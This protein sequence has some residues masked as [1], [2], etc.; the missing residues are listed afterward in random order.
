[1]QK[2]GK[3]RRGL[4]VAIAALCVVLVIGSAVAVGAA[5]GRAYN[6]RSSD[7]MTMEQ[8]REL[9]LEKVGLTN[10]TFT[11]CDFDRSDGVYELEFHH[12]RTEY[13]VEVDAYTGRI[14]DLDKDRRTHWDRVFD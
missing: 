4:I 7:P 1:M 9:A 5:V 10:A 11:K 8:A 6:R 2:T 14:W 13:E 3:K 12:D